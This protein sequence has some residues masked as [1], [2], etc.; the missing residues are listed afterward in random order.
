MKML[1]PFLVIASAAK[2]SSGGLCRSLDR[3][4]AA[5]LAMTVGGA[6]AA[7]ETN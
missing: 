2:Q 3:F 6:A 1:A 4:V 5:L 7:M